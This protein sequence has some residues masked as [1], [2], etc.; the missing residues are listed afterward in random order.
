MRDHLETFLAEA[1][2]G[3][4]AGLPAFVVR[5]MRLSETQVRRDAHF[6]PSTRKHLL[7]QLTSIESAFNGHS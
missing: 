3:S 5:A 1:A 7:A 6:S 4:D 2:R